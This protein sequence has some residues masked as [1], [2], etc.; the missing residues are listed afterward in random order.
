MNPKLIVIDTNVLLSAVLNQNVTSRQA[1][2]KA[3]QHFKIA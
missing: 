1:L 2:D 3:Y